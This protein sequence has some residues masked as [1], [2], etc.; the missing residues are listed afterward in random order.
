[1]TRRVRAVKKNRL[2]GPRRL[3]VAWLYRARGSLLA[4]VCGISLAAS[5]WYGLPRVLH[6]A[7]GHRYFALTN[8]EVDGN[9]RITR[10]EVLQWA[11][12]NTSTSI[13]DVAPDLVRLRLQ[14]HP[15]VRR[16]SVQR[17]LPNR[18]K[19]EIQEGRPVAIVRMGGLSYVDRS[20]HILGPLRDDD[21]PDF[22]LITGLEEAEPSGF[23]PVGVHRA[24]RLLRLCQR[25]NC[26]DAISEVHVDGNQGITVFPLRPAVAVVLGWGSWRE[27]LARSTRVFAA[28]EGQVERL[29]VVDVSFRGIVVVKLRAERPAA[30]RSAKKA[31]GV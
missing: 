12:V 23:S 18:L 6:L 27:K 30:G 29:A 3:P 26:F 20:G 17:E 5:V 9:H 25:L 22:P 19:I 24:L 11:G 10:G 8:V 28:W 14:S 7:M 31:L 2:W 13:W 4:A 16:A 21:S 15:W 1:M